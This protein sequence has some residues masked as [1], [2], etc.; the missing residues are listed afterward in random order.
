[1]ALSRESY[2]KAKEILEDVSNVGKSFLPG[3]EIKSPEDE[4]KTGYLILDNPH[5]GGYEAVW[6]NIENPTKEQIEKF[7]Q[8]K[9]EIGNSSILTK[10]GDLVCFGWF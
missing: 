1:M 4:W 10:K 8:R 6:I 2:I 3:F 9:G 5:N 7:N